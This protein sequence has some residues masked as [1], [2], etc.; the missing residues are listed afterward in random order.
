MVCRNY[1]I[2][3]SRYQTALLPPSID[4]YV[5][6]HNPARAID[7]YVETLNLVGLGIQTGNSGL[8]AGQPA[9]HPGMLIKLYLYGYINGIRSSRKLEREACRNLEVIWLANNLQPSYKTIAT[10]EKTTAQP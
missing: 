1:K 3:Q 8:T 6:E 9:F 2:G 10:I 5:S 7:A 4:E